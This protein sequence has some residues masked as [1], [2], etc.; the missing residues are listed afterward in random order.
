[1]PPVV[2]IIERR[3][4]VATALES[5]IAMSNLSPIVVQHLERLGDVPYTVAAIVVRVA[6][7]G[8]GE[9]AHIAVEHLPSNRP[10]IVAIATTQ[11]EIAEARRMKC[12]VVLQA[13][14]EI[15]RLCETLTKIV[16]T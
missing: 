6:F 5:A 15:N 10:P 11:E 1:M 4:E 7:E 8:L 2:L 16:G 9:P 13:P 14:Q 12:D 3:T